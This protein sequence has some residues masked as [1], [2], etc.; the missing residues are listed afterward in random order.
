MST[1]A[2][3]RRPLVIAFA[4]FAV[5]SGAAVIPSVAAAASAV[6]PSLFRGC[7]QSL[8]GSDYAAG[9][10]INNSACAVLL[11]D[12]HGWVANTNHNQ[13]GRISIDGGLVFSGEGATARRGVAAWIPGNGNRTRTCDSRCFGSGNFWATTAWPSPSAGTVFN[14]RPGHWAASGCRGAAGSA[15]RCDT[16]ATYR[17]PTFEGEPVVQR[18]VRERVSSGRMQAQTRSGH[19]T[20]CA[21]GPLIFVRCEPVGTPATGAQTRTV[22]RLSTALVTVNIINS[23]N[24]RL[25]LADGGLNFGNWARDP[26]AE[27]HEDAVLPNGQ[28]NTSIS[29]APIVASR[30]GNAVWGA[31]RP[32]STTSSAS[33]SY[34]F[35]DTTESGTN[36]NRTAVSGNRVTLTVSLDAHGK[37][38]GSSCIVTTPAGRSTAVCRGGAPDGSIVVTS[39]DQNRAV[40]VTVAPQ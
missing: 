38:N 40:T 4:G 3:Y 29:L 1:I 37:D 28:P 6:A 24:Q 35:R 18:K 26:R 16:T 5:A 27:Y 21:A 39:N 25:D 7:G 31:L 12:T 2:S 19:S 36:V 32:L 30:S 9:N 11:N 22:I 33:F 8:T 10:I 15:A 17:V 34:E 20:A 23:V 13:P 14:F